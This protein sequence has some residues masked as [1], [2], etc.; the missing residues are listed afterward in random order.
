MSLA[1]FVRKS[2]VEDACPVSPSQR[3]NGFL[4]DRRSRRLASPL[5]HFHWMDEASCT[6]KGPPTGTISASPCHRHG[7]GAILRFPLHARRL[8]AG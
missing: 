1:R 8:E 2:K 6:R 5:A 3:T 4:S 7:G